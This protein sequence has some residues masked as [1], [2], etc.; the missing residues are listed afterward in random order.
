MAAETR[1]EVICETT[2][3]VSGTAPKAGRYRFAL[4]VAA[5]CLVVGLAVHALVVVI[6]REPRVRVAYLPDDAFYYLTLARNF[7]QY[8]SWTFDS[9]V[10]LTSGFHP[11]HAYALAG[12]YALGR[13]SLEGFVSAGI[14]LSWLAALPALIG[15][16][17]YA[18][19][20]RRPLPLLLV[21]L[22][23][24]SRNVSL[25]LVSALEWGWVVSL[26]ALVFA[27]AWRAHRRP[28]RLVGLALF[29]C[30]F[31]G[32]LARTDF[33]L[34]PAALAG[35]M[36]F[37]VCTTQ[38]RARFF[39]ALCG[40]AG[41]VA[42]LAFVFA[43]NYLLTGI[44]LQSSARMKALWLEFYGPA[45]RPLLTKVLDLFGGSS[46]WAVAG[47]SV[48]GFVTLSSGARQFV[49]VLWRII[50]GG[51]A[52][53]DAKPT[54]WLA[55]LM[56]LA[57]YFVLYRH[58][59]V[60][61]QNWYTTNLVV[62]LYVAIA[63]PVAATR[64]R[65]FLSLI[66]AATVGVLL[67]AQLPETIRLRARP[68]WL[69]QATTYRAGR[70]LQE[71]GLEGLV[72][73]WNAGVVGYYSGGRVVNLDGL[74]NNDIYPY[75]VRNR[76]P[77]YIDKVGIRYIVDYAEMLRDSAKRRRGGYDVVDFNH[78]LVRVRDFPS[79]GRTSRI[80][81]LIKVRRPEE[82]RK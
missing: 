7:V 9:G 68:V 42:G 26:S 55:A 3:E 27:L 62:P 47:A 70:Y 31:A 41:A 50:P 2:T 46:Y 12:I 34:L 10:S 80:A 44:A 48:L 30:C 72:G 51:Q 16:A 21:V 60:A 67:V 52:P 29:G 49:P 19:R 40:L 54:L 38:G 28:G 39:V 13:P 57:G 25:N 43:H 8:G 79:W 32:S 35:A 73:A 20:T 36:A 65:D 33:G 14:A 71:A 81:T 56:T 23:V 18:A 64:R 22:L 53:R 5:M 1:R 63:F 17:W 69:N 59:P 4:S 75:A 24:A 11:L 45:T 6:T 37:Q 76:L 66:A 82:A 61:L 74:V 58:N 77:E 78:R 15:G